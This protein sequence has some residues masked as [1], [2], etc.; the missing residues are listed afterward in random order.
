[1]E[2]NPK[3]SIIIPVYNGAN[4]LREAIDSALAQ[5]YGNIEVIVVNDGSIDGGKTEGIA[6]SYGDRLRYYYK[7]NGGVASALNFG[8]R[9]MKGEYFSW[10]S[11][12]DV[13]YPNKVEEQI[14]YFKNINKIVILY[15]DYDL[16]DRDSKYIRAEKIKNIEPR[17][18]RYALIVGNPI[19][20]CTALVPRSC[21]EVVGTFDTRL[22]TT[23][24]YDL[25]FRMAKK[26]D[27]LHIPKVLVKS[28]VHPEQGT[29]A[30]GSIHGT[31]CNNYFIAC[32]NEMNN[33]VRPTEKSPALFNIKIAMNFKKR[34]FPEAAEYALKLS[35]KSRSEKSEKFDV[36][37]FLVRNYYDLYD[38]KIYFKGL[39]KRINNILKRRPV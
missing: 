16:I 25:W 19:N 18:F 28:R 3:V 37:Y 30:L 35:E 15:S 38:W 10:L 9:E 26:Y 20:G 7:E 23:Q 8:I 1:M 2:F 21:F 27:F 32:L 39:T 14:Q 36:K 11:H 6:K 12:D 4:F 24:D 5:T 31:E 34:K 17:D 33:D 22:K 13:Y 29:V